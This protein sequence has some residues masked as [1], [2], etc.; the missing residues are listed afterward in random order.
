MTHSL[1]DLG[2]RERQIMDILVR[3]GQATV[4]DVLG[5]LDDPPSYSAVRGMLRLL[6]EKGFVQHE[7]DGQ[8]YVYRPTADQSALRQTAA[9]HLLETFFQGSTESAVVAMLGASAHSLSTEELNRIS[10]LIEQARKN[11]GRL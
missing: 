2:R 9:R 8:R 7:S 11:G 6:K 3:R 5:D 4:A 10:A 1:T